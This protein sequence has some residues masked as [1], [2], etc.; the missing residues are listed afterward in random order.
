MIWVNGFDRLELG[1][2]SGARGGK[3][4]CLKLN[5]PFFRSRQVKLSEPSRAVV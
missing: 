1:V 3:A 5:A 2:E 4:Y